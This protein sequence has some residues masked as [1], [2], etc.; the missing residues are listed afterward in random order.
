MP[1]ARRAP[2]SRRRHKKVLKKAKGFWG[3]RHRLY[4][5]AVETLVRGMYFSYRDRK[6]K[7]RVYR[8]LWI[9]RL[10]AACRVHGLSYS[11]FVSG[12]KKAK[13]TLDRKQLAEIC[14]SDNTAFQ[15]LVEIAKKHGP[16]KA[17]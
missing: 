3:A 14:V 5:P 4:R 16:K 12:L 17:A 10:N 8:G 6:K 13:V 11:R 1:R 9:Q 2:A 15:E 7:K